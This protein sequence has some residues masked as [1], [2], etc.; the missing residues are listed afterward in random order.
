MTSSQPAK[1]QVPWL[2]P[3]AT[4][5]SGLDAASLPERV[6]KRI[7]DCA[8]DWWGAV[9]AGCNHR[10][11]ETYRQSLAVSLS[12]TGPLSTGCSVAGWSGSYLLEQAAVAN[13]AISHLSEVD[14]GHK[15]A[16]MHPG[17]TV[18]PTV[19]AMAEQYRVSMADIQAAIVAGYEVGL[20]VGTLLGKRHYEV[21]H[22]TATAGCFGATAAAARLLR[23]SPQQ[24]LFAFGHAGTQAA[25]LWQLLDDGAQEAKAFHPAA[26][27]RNGLTAV[28]LARNGL[29]AAT[30]I[31]E[32]P[33][34][35]LKAWGLNGDAA[36]LSIPDSDCYQIETTSIKG[37]PVCGQMHT[38]LDALSDLLPQVGDIQQVA[39]I[40]VKAP[41]AQLEIANIM[42]PQSFEEAKFSSRFCLSFLLHEGRL[43]F[44][45]FGSQVLDSCVVR[46]FMDKI[47]IEEEISFTDRFP[48]ERPAK[49]E[50]MLKNGTLLKRER[51]F[52]RG[53]PEQ[54]WRWNDLVKR[55][56]ALTPHLDSK[57]QEKLID[58]CISCGR[59]GISTSYLPDL[60]AH[61]DQRAHLN[62]KVRF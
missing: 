11:A 51:S 25:G 45:N 46:N 43:D 15:L 54:P 56:I 27:T 48:K 33:R 20:K 9:A 17:V 49:V 44:E 60:F 55:F 57:A 59:S 31:L 34:G 52:R 14:D 41:K 62:R 28:S 50:I 30:H 36:I 16:A 19:I 1:Q 6:K 7:A 21:C 61:L 10:L 29:T 26:A 38:S 58:W 2:Q 8:I 37:W 42:E 18:F 4:W 35:L 5:V 22:T 53:D 24:T 23:L 47:T 32:G 13:S 39:S 3:L 12:P 40:R